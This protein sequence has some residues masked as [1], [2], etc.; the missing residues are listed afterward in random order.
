[1]I[2]DNTIN[3]NMR[4]QIDGTNTL[5]K[6]AELMLVAIIEEI[7]K[8]YPDSV[9]I[10]NSNHSNEKK[11]IIKT[12][13][14]IIKRFWLKNSRIPIAI[15]SRLKLPY[16]FFTSKHASKNIDVVL[17]AS[18]FQFSDQWNYSQERLEKLEKYFS[19]LKSYGS[20]IVLLPQALGP[21]NTEA[22]K[23]SVEIINKYSD[24]IIAR[25]QVSFDYVVNAG[26]N[27][28]KVW[29][30]PDFTLLVKGTLPE[31]YIHL[32]GKVCIIPNKKMVTHTKTRSN[33]YLNFLKKIIYEFK[34]LGKDVFLLNHEG[35]GDFE[36]CK[37]I[38]GMLSNPLEIVTDLNAKEVKG[39]IGASFI[40]VSSRFHGVASALS[41]EVP[42]LATSW[43][44]KY[45]MLFEDYD[46]H[47]RIINVDEDWERTKDKIHEVFY[48]HNEIKSVLGLKKIFLSS[49]IEHMWNKIWAT[50]FDSQ[51]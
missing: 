4:I 40:T 35:L 44:H 36:I 49:E 33:E 34:D 9:I 15:L 14:T 29:K 10:Y 24:I 51:Q 1:M 31:K 13:L 43:N 7:E 17:D 22:G 26:A 41:Q 27:V 19:S 11:L 21:F 42:C 20:K 16:V 23:R 18:G 50:V 30:Y 25:E 46:Q 47:E 48:K 5:N 2:L 6:G 3:R 37:E 12:G 8:K 39:V 38:N 32:V 28:A 45:K